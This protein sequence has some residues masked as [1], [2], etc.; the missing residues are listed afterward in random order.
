MSNIAE[1]IIRIRTEKWLLDVAV[2]RSL[3][4]GKRS[5]INAD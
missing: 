2:W 1:K 4:G 3:S 5:P